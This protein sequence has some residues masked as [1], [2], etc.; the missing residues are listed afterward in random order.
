MSWD[1][2]EDKC[3]WDLNRG[4]STSTRVRINSTAMEV[5]TG[6]ELRYFVNEEI[7]MFISIIV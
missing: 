3:K 4:A 5:K 2:R 6:L 7:E 1:W